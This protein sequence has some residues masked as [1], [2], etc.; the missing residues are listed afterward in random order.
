[1]NFKQRGL[2]CAGPLV[3]KFSIKILAAGTQRQGLHGTLVY[4]QVLRHDASNVD[5]SRVANM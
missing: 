4:Q 5:I 2:L 3:G 1:V